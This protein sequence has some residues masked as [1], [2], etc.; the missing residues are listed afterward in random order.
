MP[1]V[2]E[3]IWLRTDRAAEGSQPCRAS[4]E[5]RSGVESRRPRTWSTVACANAHRQ[6]DHAAPRAWMARRNARASH[7]DRRGPSGR[8]PAASSHDVPIERDPSDR[9]RSRVAPKGTSPISARR[10]PGH[11]RSKRATTTRTRGT[12]PPSPAKS[13]MPRPRLRS[14]AGFRGRPSSR[15]AGPR[16]KPAARRPPAWRREAGS[17]LRSHAADPRR[18][19][20]R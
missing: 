1:N 16:W 11:P 3:R 8:P 6:T 2:T 13:T 9:S 5:G 15:P 10:A 7:R 4:A 20:A 18:R 19:P 17:L 12:N 14:H